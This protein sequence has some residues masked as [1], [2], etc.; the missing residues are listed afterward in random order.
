MASSNTPL[1]LIVDDQPSN[2]IS[3]KTSVANL[4]YR[5]MQNN[6]I[7]IGDII[8]I[9]SVNNKDNISNTNNKSD[10]LPW[11]YFNNNND[12]ND[13]S[14]NDCYCSIMTAWPSQK[15]SH[16]H[17]QLDSI[18][19]E[20]CNVKIGD[21][22]YLYKTPHQIIN[23]ES[24][25][26]PTTVNLDCDEIQIQ[27]ETPSHQKYV[28]QL[29]SF[30][31]LQ[32]LVLSQITG[33][34][35]IKNNIF[36]INISNNLIKFKIINL[37]NNNYNSNSNSN[38]KKND[39]NDLNIDFNK[40]NLNDSD[41]N[42]NNN[43]DFIKSIF[44]I[45]NKTNIKLINQKNTINNNTN[46]NNVNNNNNNIKNKDLNYELIGGLDNQ[47][48]QIREIIELSFYKSKLLNSFGIKPPKGILLYGP[49]GT[50][51]TLLARIVSNQTNATL[52][53]INGADILDKFYG[54]TEKTLL[55]IF[56][57]A[58][59]KA[60]SIIFIDELDALCP[61]RE[62]NS[63][64]VEKRVVGSL[65]TLM[66]GI[67][68][69]GG[70]EENEEENEN[71][72]KVIVIGCTNRPD[73]IDS[74]LRRPGRFD[75][76]IEISIPNQQGREQILKIF[77]SKIPNQLNEKEINFISSKTHGFVGADIESL[78]K[79]ASLKCFNRIKNENLSLF[80]NNENNNGLNSILELIK[81]SMEDM[82]L[83]LNQ[84]KPS[85]MREVVVEIPKVYWND[86][87]GQEH[88]KQKLKEAIEW[89]LKHPESFIRMGIKP[90]K[91]ILLYGPPGCS[92]TLLAKAL[93]T[94]SGLNFIAVKG[95]E[96]LSKWVGES[97]RAVRDIFKKARQNA[98][99][100]LFF[101]EIDG[102]AISRSGEGSGAVERVVSQLLT[103]MDGIQPLTNVTIIGA[104]NRPDII[105][106]AILRAGRI[107]RILYIS[108]P[109]FDARKEIFNI[110]LKKVPHSNDINVEELSN[111]TDGY[112]GAEVTSICRE[113]SI[114][115][116][117][118]DLNAKQI[119]MNHFIQAISNVKKGITK[120][121]L[122]FYKQYQENSNLQ[123]L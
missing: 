33:R 106:K 6:D 109:D 81:V 10:E 17:I 52:F 38:N 99:S 53:T 65:L 5:F 84:V 113:A 30:G 64:E 100:I 73:S 83:A 13:N 80:L 97:E 24:S 29:F 108:P 43:K 101:D 57:E 15:L 98:P 89:P 40:L 105:D 69:G 75:N 37:I 62:E 54:M 8:Y 51:K 11:E 20:N 95:P 118:Q 121:M 112:S 28:S 76:E 91:G 82:L 16:T 92:K 50:G 77:L 85:S 66:D 34:F 87:G 96:L 32:P 56:K 46:N 36:T 79:E 60:P 86:I 90:P 123:V 68:I 61:K 7:T 103:E 116:M 110:H 114:C 78:C 47:V 122:N 120:E 3:K 22:V 39:D 12:N 94:E 19:R 115:A 72:N 9:V 1:K 71:K 41:N 111:L 74:A 23:I 107:D 26:K 25:N 42:N 4:S 45:Y 59:R 49:P 102:L 93:A 67:A 18:Q 48:K 70:N 58:S 88:I 119:E 27:C 63:S 31:M 55:N 21:S 2:S 14:E 35:F 117:K 104:T 44:R